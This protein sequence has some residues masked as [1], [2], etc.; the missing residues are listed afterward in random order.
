MFGTAYPI[1]NF[2]SL[3]KFQ[4][5]FLIPCCLVAAKDRQTD[6]HIHT[7]FYYTDKAIKEQNT[8][9][10]RGCVWKFIGFK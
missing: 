5:T 2:K 7:S 9:Y 10:S 8:I 4:T 1:S 6:R 3:P